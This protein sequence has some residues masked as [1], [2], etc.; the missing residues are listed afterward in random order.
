MIPFVHIGL[1]ILHGILE[2]HALW[3]TAITATALFLFF[4]VVGIGC[5]IRFSKRTSAI[6]ATLLIA[7]TVFAIIPFIA[8]IVPV[9][10]Y[11]QW[12]T[13]QDVQEMIISLSP[14]YWLGYPL[15]EKNMSDFYEFGIGYF[16]FLTAYGL[17]TVILAIT[18]SGSLRETLSRTN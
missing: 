1:C 9:F 2:F 8:S 15:V 14:W 10:T 7:F 6:V 17:L 5:S 13:A 4:I 16:W 3:L 18:S 11:Y 12:G